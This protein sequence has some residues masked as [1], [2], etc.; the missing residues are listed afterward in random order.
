[1][2]I[3]S[4]MTELA[5]DIASSHD[6][7]AKRI[8]EI[9]DEVKVARREAQDL[10]GGF[11][12]TRKNETA[13]LRRD[14]ARGKTERRSEVKKILTGFQGSRREESARMCKELAQGVADT[15]SAVGGILKGAQQTVEGFRS[16]RKQMGA[17]MRKELAQSKASNKSEVARMSQGFQ[18]SRTE[19][20]AQM[21]KE[22]AQ[23]VAQ[24]RSDVREMRRDFHQAQAEVVADLKAAKVAWQDLARTMQ[25]KRARVEVPPKAEVPVPA[26]QVPVEEEIPDLGAKLLAA[27]SEHPQGITLTEVA[28]GLGVTPIVL[29]RASRKLLDEGKIRKEGKAYFPVASE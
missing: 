17:Q 21:R 28:E 20:G 9:K 15:K 23:T 22:L 10:L 27:I 7:R 18:N 16:D 1:M 25:A 6:D 13:Q 3:A 5:Q 2:G 4:G 12:T 29:G 24:R 11:R 14:L 8:G 26:K 19:E